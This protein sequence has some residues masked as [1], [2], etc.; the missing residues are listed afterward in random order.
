M[1][2]QQKYFLGSHLERRLRFKVESAYSIQQ[3]LISLTRWKKRIVLLLTDIPLVIIALWFSF[4]L[5]LG[6]WYWPASIE[7]AGLLL[8]APAIA[9]PIFIRF[10]LYRAIIRYLGMRAAWAVVQAVA[11]YAVLWGLL[12][13][14]SGVPGIPRSVVLINAM[15]AL[16]A[17]G[18]S[19]MLMRW[20]LNQVQDKEEQSGIRGRTRLVIFGAG[21]AGRQ[22]AT[23]LAQSRDYRLFGFVDD[24]VELQ[25][26]DLMGVPILSLEQLGPFIEKHE[27][28]DLLLAIPSIFRQERNQIIE[29]LRLLPLRVRT[30]PG[31]AEMARGKVNLSD[32][33]E[34]EIEDLLARDPAL[35][36]EALLDQ[37]VKE[38]V[39]LVTGA[40]GSIGSEIC[41]QV[42]RR[43]PKTLLLLDDSEFALFTIHN[44]LLELIHTLMSES[45]SE[46][47]SESRG[48]S[49]VPKVVPLI[50]A[51]QNEER[52]TAILQSWKVDMIYHA[53]AKKHVPLSE[54]NFSET[55]INNVLGTLSVVKAAIIQSVPDVVL[56]STDKAV[57]PT[58][59]MG[60]TKRVA[61]MILQA[62]VAEKRP[63]FESLGEP[64]LQV[65]RQTHLSMVRFGNVLGSS[66]S[67]VP[68]FRK[69]ILDGGPITLTH[70]EIIRYFMTIPEAA[71]LVMQAGAMGGGLEELDGSGDLAFDPLPG[72]P[73]ARGRGEAA[74]VFVLDMGEPVKI[75][76]LARRMIQLSGLRLKSEAS[77]EGDIEIKVVGLREGEK[78][79]EELLIGDDPLPTEHPKIMKA[80]EEF[81][82]WDELQPKLNSLQIAAQNYDV[83]LC[84]AIIQELVKGYTPD[85]VISDHLYRAQVG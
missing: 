21:E 46:S 41:R 22:L 60:A 49:L 2:P 64:P 32:L 26:R 48:I 52:V 31:L 61:E 38:K 83:E 77:P 47:E 28:T 3:K 66:G 25:G 45:E 44:E 84:R 85:E 67:V 63:A 40:G 73:P 80:H 27:I 42:I 33:H 20:L 58:N 43:R 10:G 50:G 29:R 11:L 13:L 69:Q 23:G 74:E 37:Q 5:R 82:P 36:D 70:K 39:F 78:L 68:H 79:Y 17:V 15:V 8:A 51:V 14:L 30:L 1:Q 4:S 18:G 35:P 6:Q 75:Y 54:G 71:Q 59:L 7:I 53:A 9:V 16:L 81:I 34:L 76:D 55:I 62:L 65:E 24:A 57:R 12:A 56:I 72:P 19:R